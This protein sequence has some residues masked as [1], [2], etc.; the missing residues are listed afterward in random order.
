MARLTPR[1]LAMSFEVWPEDRRVSSPLP[2]RYG[3]R[4]L[5]NAGF[6]ATMTCSGMFS[7]ANTWKLAGTGL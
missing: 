6:A 2:T 5:G 1:Y 3:P 7:I 4:N